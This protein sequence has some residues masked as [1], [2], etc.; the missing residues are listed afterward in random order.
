MEKKKLACGDVVPSC[1]FQAEA[2]TESELLQKVAQHAAHEHDLQEVSP[3]LLAKVKS[4][5]RTT[6]D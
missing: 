1:K 2:S 6:H 3:E 4:A 5:I